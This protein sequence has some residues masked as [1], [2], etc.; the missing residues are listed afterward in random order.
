M[1]DTEDQKEDNDSFD[2]KTDTPMPILFQT[3]LPDD[4][5]TNNDLGAIAALIAEGSDETDNAATLNTSKVKITGKGRGK[6]KGGKAERTRRYQRGGG[7][8][9]YE[10]K[11]GVKR[12]VAV[13]QEEERGRR[14]DHNDEDNED[15]EGPGN[16]ADATDVK[17]KTSDATVAEATLFLD[18]WKP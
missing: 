2:T 1:D 9:P 13:D 6:G 5:R 14:V 11:E 8:T 17:K 18:L 7:G 15:G 4:F 16:V 12:K 10:K 3:G